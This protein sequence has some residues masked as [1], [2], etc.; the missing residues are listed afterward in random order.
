M[1]EIFRLTDRIT[2]LKNGRC[3]KTVDTAFVDKD[4][5]IGLMTDSWQSEALSGAQAFGEELLTVE[6]LATKDGTVKDMSFRV[7]SGEILGVF[8]L[9]G[10]G[11]TEALECLYGLPCGARAAA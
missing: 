2:V 5:L 1:D 8:G 10:S 3:V 6:H 4:Q 9:G 11:R 7:R